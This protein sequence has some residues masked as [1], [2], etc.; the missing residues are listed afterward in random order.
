MGFIESFSRESIYIRSLARTLIS[1]RHV[2]P[3]SPI[4]IVDI[5]EH[6]AQHRGSNTAIVCGDDVLTYAMLNA[7]ANQ[8]AHWARAQNIAQRDVVALLMDNRPEYIAAWLGLLKAG[9][10]IALINSNLRGH[11]LA[12]SI[13]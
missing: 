11:P 13:S 9:A 5:L 7:R 2:K 8:Y 3:D 12:H 10:T 4:T 6:H 1:M